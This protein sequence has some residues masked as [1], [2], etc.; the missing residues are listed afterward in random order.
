MAARRHLAVLTLV[1]QRLDNITGRPIINFSWSTAHG[2]QDSTKC[3][4]P[5]MQLNRA[6][7]DQCRHVRCH[8][9]NAILLGCLFPLELVTWR[10]RHACRFLEISQPLSPRRRAFNTIPSTALAG[11]LRVSIIFAMVS[12]R[13]GISTAQ[14]TVLRLR[15][16]SP[17]GISASQPERPYRYR[18]IANCI[19]I[20]AAGESEL[21]NL[22][23]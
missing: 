15:Y 11:S 14:T 21:P 1:M 3:E 22:A 10:N 18:D 9:L 5:T 19:R 8:L 2:L 16:R 6:Q 12:K 7:P 23:T 17:W 13:R 20:R 4:E